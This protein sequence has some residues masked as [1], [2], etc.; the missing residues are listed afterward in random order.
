[1]KIEVFVYTRPNL[2]TY[3]VEMEM[4][5]G[6]NVLRGL[7]DD[8]VMMPEVKRV[9]L[10]FPERWLNILEQRALLHR[11]EHFCPNC[12]SVT[13]KTHSVYIVQ[14]CK[15]ENVFI[16][17]PVEDIDETSDCTV[18][19]CTEENEGNL[20]EEGKLNVL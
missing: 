17:K 3:S 19:M 1:M 2:R 20:L 5:M 9:F 4:Y 6:T 14:V 10:S 7:F 18:R 13:I 8:M 16:I 15:S 11:I 12:E